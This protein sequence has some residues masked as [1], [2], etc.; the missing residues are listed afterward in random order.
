MHG[1]ICYIEIAAK[2][3]AKSSAFYTRVFSW[4]TRKRGDGMLAFDDASGGVSGSWLDGKTKPG[5]GM[6][7]YVQ[8][9][10]ID[11]ASKEIEAAGGKI[12]TKKTAIDPSGN[13]HFAI[14]TD[15][16]GNEVGLYEQKN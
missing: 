14:F 5:A 15:P 3:I 11:Q 10:S 16:A 1:K 8:V 12:T 9:D 7:T 4:K 6:R 2:D 13:A